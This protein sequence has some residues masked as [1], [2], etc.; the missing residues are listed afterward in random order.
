MRLP[1]FTAEAAVAAVTRSYR[2]IAASGAAV[3]VVALA[4][5]FD[6]LN[7]CYDACATLALD[8]SGGDIEFAEYYYNIC[9][10]GCNDIYLRRRRV[11]A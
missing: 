5:G 9:R 7:G 11:R 3:P 6:D 10:A 1:G 4:Q 2:V 8:A